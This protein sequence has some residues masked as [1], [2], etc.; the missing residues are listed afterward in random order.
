MGVKALT[1]LL[2]ESY[3]VS[4]FVIALFESHAVLA[5]FITGIEDYSANPQIVVC[6]ILLGN[7]VSKVFL[8]L[9]SPVKAIKLVG[10]IALFVLTV[11][12]IIIL[13]QATRKIAINYAKRMV[14][15]KV[16]GGQ[17][18]HLPIRLNYSGV[19]P[20]IFASAIISF[21]AVII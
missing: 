4:T 13:T 11:A 14:G 21:P 5:A 17:S 18:T 6:L 1:K 12:G 10:L 15:R 7:V 19:M 2:P 3:F 20:I 8:T 16:M 9:K